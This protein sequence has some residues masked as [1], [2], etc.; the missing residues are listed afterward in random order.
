MADPCLRKPPKT[1]ACS[2]KPAGGNSLFVKIT[3]STPC[4][5]QRSL[6]ARLGDSFYFAISKIVESLLRRGARCRSTREPGCVYPNK[7][8]RR[9]ANASAAEAVPIGRFTGH[10]GE[11]TVSA[12]AP[13]EIIPDKLTVYRLDFLLRRGARGFSL[14][15]A[16]QTQQKPLWGRPRGFHLDCAL[17]QRAKSLL[18]RAT[19][20]ARH[21]KAGVGSATSF[22]C[23]TRAAALTPGRRTLRVFYRPAGCKLLRLRSRAGPRAR[24]ERRGEKRR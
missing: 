14:H 23:P 7:G 8:P 15:F 18:R 1:G 17:A 9:D 13:G 6:T 16:T 4:S 5:A 20:A 11:K 22:D 21:S 24:G 2:A 19:G 3:L 12:R 10:S